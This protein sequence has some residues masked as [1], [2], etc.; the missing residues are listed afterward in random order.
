MYCVLCD[1]M[2]LVRH[3]LRIVAGGAEMRHGRI[4]GLNDM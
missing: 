4:V 2:K 3:A 1:D